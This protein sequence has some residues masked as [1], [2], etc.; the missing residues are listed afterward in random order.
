MLGIPRLWHWCVLDCRLAW[1]CGAFV[2]CVV[3]PLCVCVLVVA[4]GS[5]QGLWLV[6]S[7]T[8]QPPHGG[9]VRWSHSTT[10]PL[11]M[12]PFCVCVCVWDE[13]RVVMVTMVAPSH[14]IAINN[15]RTTC[16][17]SI[18]PLTHLSAF[19]L[20]FW[21][22]MAF[23]KVCVAWCVAWQPLALQHHIWHTHTSETVIGG[24]PNWWLC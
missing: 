11:S 15:T 24:T 10:V 6:M 13:T 7:H 5:H 12:C 14:C 21:L 3:Q 9:V 19:F 1:Q 4:F 17:S 23:N 20:A 8:N 16:M 2:C 18:W 22:L